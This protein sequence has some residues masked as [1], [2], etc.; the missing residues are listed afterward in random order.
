MKLGIFSGT[1][2]P[3]HD[4]HIWLARTSIAQ[5]G[6]DKVAFLPETKPRHKSPVASYRHRKHMLELAIG[7]DDKL[8][9]LDIPTDSHGVKSTLGF[10]HKHYDDIE[11]T[12]DIIM[13]AE[14]LKGV[15]KWNDFEYLKD[16]S[17]FIVCLRNEADREGVNILISGLGLDAK[18]INSNFALVSSS[19]IRRELMKSETPK[20]ID[21]NVRGYIKKN[22]LYE[23]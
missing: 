12:V 17:S 22:K 16:Q 8:D 23:T 21:H 14:V 11:K 20:N 18:V 1:F 15:A 2:D 9:V 7:N 3:V 13:G 4:G 19:Q 6:L 10:I 5:F